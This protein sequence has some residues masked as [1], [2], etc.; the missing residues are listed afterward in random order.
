MGNAN[1]M[2]ISRRIPLLV[3]RMLD[4]AID[5]I[6]GVWR[7]RIS[8]TVELLAAGTSLCMPFLYA[9]ANSESS[10]LER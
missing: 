10:F 1:R 8:E 5:I 6:P 2:D 3:S 4:Q 9:L 7:R